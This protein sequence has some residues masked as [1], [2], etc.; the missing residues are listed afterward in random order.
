MKKTLAYMFLAAGCVALVACDEPYTKDPNENAAPQVSIRTE[1]DSPGL[2]GTRDVLFRDALTGTTTALSRAEGNV[3]NFEWDGS[4]LIYPTNFPFIRFNKLLDGSTIETT[5]KDDL[6]G[7]DLGDCGPI[8]GAV[9]VVEDGVPVTA[10]RTC[11]SPSD[12][13]IGIQLLN[14]ATPR[15]YLRYDTPYSFKVTDKIKD[16]KGRAL[17]PY[18]ADVRTRPFMLLSASDLAKLNYFYGAPGTGFAS[19]KKAAELPFGTAVLRL[20]FSG[21]MQ[22]KLDKNDDPTAGSVAVELGLRT[23]KLLSIDDQGN[24]TEVTAVNPD[25]MTAEPGRFTFALDP[26]APT[27]RDTRTVFVYSPQA[28]FGTTDDDSVLPSGDYKI[29]LPTSVT[30][31]GTVLGTD[32]APVP[33]PLAAQVELTFTIGEKEEE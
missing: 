21:P 5:S 22:V 24:E 26:S 27:T 30:D 31:N 12:T 20:V 1:E 33:V 18:S 2:G 17:E 23:A 3:M 6:T 10:L 15:Q 4:S 19:I 8:P 9:E 16:K 29:V 7:R 13:L 11:Y 25:S 14:G 28:L 32:T